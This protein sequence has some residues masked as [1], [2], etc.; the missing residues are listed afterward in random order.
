MRKTALVILISLVTVSCSEKHHTDFLPSEGICLE[1][2]GK[3]ILQYDEATCQLGFNRDRCEFRV[4]TD[5]ASDYFVLQLSD[6]PAEEG[7][8]VFGKIKW[9]TPSR[10]ESRKDVAFKVMKLEGDKIWL[11]NSSGKIAVCV[12]LI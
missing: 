8:T 7:E 5:N 10:V 12:S 4:L 2:T 3:S 9:T 6:I 1:V 11:W